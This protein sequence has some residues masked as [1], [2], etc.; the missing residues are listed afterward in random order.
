MA[1]GVPPRV[2]HKVC[3]VEG[4]GNVLTEQVIRSN[5]SGKLKLPDDLSALLCAMFARFVHK[6][7]ALKVENRQY[8][9]QAIRIF[10]EYLASNP[11][12]ERMYTE[13]NES[14]DQEDIRTT[15]HGE[16]DKVDSGDKK[17]D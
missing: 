11:E 17:A 14:I 8:R 9:P 12:I 10:S 2:I 3:E 5:L 16:N 15:G 1:L 4:G 13:F 6:C 7:D